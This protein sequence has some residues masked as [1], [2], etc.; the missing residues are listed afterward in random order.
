MEAVME[1]SCGDPKGFINTR[2]ET[3]KRRPVDLRL[4]DWREVYEPF[5]TNKL[6]LQAGRCMDCGI[7]FAITAVL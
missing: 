7:L 1:V 6:K 3:P 4:M 5:E 2:R